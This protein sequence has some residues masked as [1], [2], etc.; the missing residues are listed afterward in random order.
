MILTSKGDMRNT[1]NTKEHE[2]REGIRGTRGT[3][4]LWRRH[5]V[6]EEYP[7]VR[8]SAGSAPEPVVFLV[9]L[10]FLPGVS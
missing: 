4:W 10:V 2:E 7:V 3:P 6:G 8:K 9:F 5:R 1:K